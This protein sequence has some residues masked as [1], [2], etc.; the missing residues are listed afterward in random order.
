MMLP[1]H[2]FLQ[3]SPLG[4]PRGPRVP[5]IVFRNRPTI[6]GVKKVSVV[7]IDR[8]GDGHESVVYRAKPSRM[9][10]ILDDLMDDGVRVSVVRPNSGVVRSGELDDAG[11]RKRKQTKAVRPMERGMRKVMRRQLDFAQL[12]L[13]RHE[14]SNRRKRDGWLKDLPRNVFRAMRD[15]N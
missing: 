8:R 2:A 14:R 4:F 6:A 7:R 10:S 12:Y 9:E 3:Y 15:S 13:A 11:P 5:H 1:I